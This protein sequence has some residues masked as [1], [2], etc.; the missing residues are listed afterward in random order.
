MEKHEI[1]ALID[2]CNQYL[3]GNVTREALQQ[4]LYLAHWTLE[5]GKTEG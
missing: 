3:N 1:L 4:A 2:E 5:K